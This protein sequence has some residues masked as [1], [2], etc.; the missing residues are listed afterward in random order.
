[1]SNIFKMEYS[2]LQDL[3]LRLQM[4]LIT[5]TNEDDAFEYRTRLMMIEMAFEEMEA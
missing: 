1:M 2:E 5:T 4:D 3:Q